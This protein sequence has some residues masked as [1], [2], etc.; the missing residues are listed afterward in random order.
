MHIVFSSS[1]K[2]SPEK[3][4]ASIGYFKLDIQC[5][6]YYMHMVWSALLVFVMTGEFPTQMASNAENVSIWWRHHGCIRRLGIESQLTWGCS[7]NYGERYIV[8]TILAFDDTHI[9]RGKLKKA[10]TRARSNPRT[11]VCEGWDDFKISSTTCPEARELDRDRRQD[12]ETHGG[13][14]YTLTAPYCV[15]QVKSSLY[16]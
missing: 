15:G 6:S 2:I 13:R 7:L 4:N 11:T 9:Q 12:I 3:L 1:N 14:T 16:Y 5:V 10:T 8:L